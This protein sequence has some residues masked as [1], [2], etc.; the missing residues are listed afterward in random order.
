VRRQ[1]RQALLDALTVSTRDFG[2]EIMDVTL[3]DIEFQGQV[4]EEWAKTWRT[5]RDIEVQKIES[6][7]RIQELKMRERAVN[8]V[9]QEMLDRLIGTLTTMTEE[10]RLDQISMDYVLLGFIDMIER[11]AAAQKVFIPED[12]LMRFERI[13]KEL[14]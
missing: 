6:D 3:H 7:E 1:I 10:R 2:V 11:T 4:L 12:S 9:R 8:Q 14:R 5:R 13:K